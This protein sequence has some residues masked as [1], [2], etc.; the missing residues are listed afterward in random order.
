LEKNKT[1]KYFKYAIGEIVFVVIGILLA[2]QINNWKE[3]TKSKSI[4]REYLIGIQKNLDKD[5]FELNKLIGKDTMH[6]QNYSTLLK[7][8]TDKS[9]NKYSNE[10]LGA[11]AKSYSTQSFQGNNIVF[12]DMKFSGKINYIQTDVLRFSILE[13]YNESQKVESLQNKVNL[14]QLINHREEAFVNNLDMNSL[15]E[16]FMFPENWRA[17][18]DPLD[19]SFFDSDINSEAVKNFANRISL[20]KLL[21]LENSR[22]D[23]E[24]VLKAQRL[25][26]KITEYLSTGMVDGEG[27][28]SIETLSAIK[29]GDIDK[30]NVLIQKKTI[31]NCFETNF[32][33]TNYLVLAIFSESMES[34]KYFIEQG[35]NFEHVCENK[36]PLMYASKYDKLNMV[37]YLV[38]LGAD[39]NFV[40]IK[41]KTALDYAIQYKRPEVTAYLKGLNA[42]QVDSLD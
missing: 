11:I 5:I 17:E 34:L 37:K 12:E 21:V 22:S 13:Y 8:F 15:I 3:N 29:E 26:S 41:G 36:T 35:A 40:S 7:A 38:D 20:M 33:S 27:Y 2:L 23:Y 6:F 18:I 1:G 28:I 19:L 42:K 24:L 25:K 30:L 16:K 32:G 14:P 9:I 4:E 39:I 10:F 31:N